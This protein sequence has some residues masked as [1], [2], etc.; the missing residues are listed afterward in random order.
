M[1]HTVYVNKT[2]VKYVNKTVPVYINRTVYVYV[3]SNASGSVDP[4][5]DSALCFGKMVVLNN[6]TA[7]LA[8]A[9]MIPQYV[10]Q[11]LAPYEGFGNNATAV[12]CPPGTPAVVANGTTWCYPGI[13]ISVGWPPSQNNDMD[14]AAEVING[15]YMFTAALPL[16]EVNGYYMTAFLYILG[17][18]YNSKNG[19]EVFQ[20][21]VWTYVNSLLIAYFTYTPN[22]TITMTGPCSI[23]VLGPFTPSE[24]EQQLLP[25]PLW[26][27]YRMIAG[28]NSTNYT[29]VHEVD[30]LWQLL[31]SSSS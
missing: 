15:T 7:W 12:L 31:S 5:N 17:G 25:L 23:G 28:V 14:Y 16:R 4:M 30:L 11:V 9:I 1:N 13:D 29:F 8:G 20:N 10:A 24:A 26:Q 19:M 6:G 21:G 3:P 18:T 27:W 22:G 2:I